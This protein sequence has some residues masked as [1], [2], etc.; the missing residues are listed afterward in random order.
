MKEGE[1]SALANDPDNKDFTRPNIDAVTEENWQ[2][3]AAEGISVLAPCLD[4]KTLPAYLQ[5]AQ[6]MWGVAHVLTGDAFDENEQ[7]PLR[8]KPGHGI[9]VRPE[10]RQYFEELRGYHPD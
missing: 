5:Y 9:Y 8:L 2:E 1:G 10:G 6:S 7:R 3:L 4:D